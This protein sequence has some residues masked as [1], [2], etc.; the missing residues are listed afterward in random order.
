[1]G[2][3]SHTEA[4]SDHS[5]H[6][7]TEAALIPQGCR[8][9]R[10]NG[11]GKQGTLTDPGAAAAR[12]PPQDDESSSTRVWREVNEAPTTRQPNRHHLPPIPG[13]GPRGPAPSWRTSSPSP[14]QP[15]ERDRQ[16]FTQAPTR[17][18]TVRPPLLLPSSQ[19]RRPVC[20][21]GDGT[22]RTHGQGDP[23]PTSNPNRDRGDEPLKP[24]P[25]KQG[26]TAPAPDTGTRHLT[27]WANAPQGSQPR[28]R[29][30]QAAGVQKTH[31]NNGDTT[32]AT[33]ERTK[34]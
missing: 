20:Y 31:H 6:G 34:K 32:Q 10:Q 30:S 24:P 16:R 3:P 23:R 2:Y 13:V 12:R 22:P 26:V 15:G 11:T 8:A 1:M 25:R 14:R 19:G 28:L 5:P 7:G 33:R 29:R 17:Q 21:R 18:Q 27:N 9:A 4:P